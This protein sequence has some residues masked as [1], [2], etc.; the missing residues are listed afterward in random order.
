MSGPFKIKNIMAQTKRQAKMKAYNDKYAFEKEQYKREKG[1]TR[2]FSKT[3]TAKRILKNKAAAKRKLDFNSPAI[4]KKILKTLSPIQVIADR[5][6]YHL[7]LSYGS[8]ADRFAMQE[9]KNMKNGGKK[10][11]V[12]FHYTDEVEEK[13]GLKPRRATTLKDFSSIMREA[14]EALNEA[15]AEEESLGDY[16]YVTV[17]EAHD[18]TRT[19]I[20][21]LV[22]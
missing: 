22:E 1:N 9:F 8:G 16:F 2:G 20:Q 14:Y 17:T 4:N 19:Y 3:E 15:Q 21:F 13:T 10:P 12:F 18:A 5:L 11:I 7:V 6:I